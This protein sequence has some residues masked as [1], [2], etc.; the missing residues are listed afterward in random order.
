MTASADRCLEIVFCTCNPLFAI[1]TRVAERASSLKVCQL[2]HG[3]PSA[4]VIP[5]EKEASSTLY[6]NLRPQVFTRIEL[7]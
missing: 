4:E 1:N 7:L 2:K 5:Y 3:A 6:E